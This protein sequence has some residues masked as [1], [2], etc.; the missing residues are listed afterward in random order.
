MKYIKTYENDKFWLDDPNE[1]RLVYKYRSY[2]EKKYNASSVLLTYNQD[3]L[4]FGLGRKKL[5]RNELIHLIKDFDKY[6]WRIETSGIG[7]KH[8]YFYVPMTDDEFKSYFEEIDKQ[9]KLEEDTD[10]YNL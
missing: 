6:N 4:E 8:V 10:K 5:S 7:D 3:Q 9:I 1:K 2:L